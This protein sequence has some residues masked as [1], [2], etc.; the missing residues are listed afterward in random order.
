MEEDEDP[1]AQYLR[2]LKPNDPRGAT[3]ETIVSPANWLLRTSLVGFFGWVFYFVA[4]MLPVLFPNKDEGG[5]ATVERLRQGQVQV[6]RQGAG[7]DPGR[8]PR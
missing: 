5:P 8:R 1:T 6:Q 4:F 2:N 3:Q 7:S